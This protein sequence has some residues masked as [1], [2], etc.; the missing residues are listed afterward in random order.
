MPSNILAIGDI[1]GQPGRKALG[2]LLGDLR[3]DYQAELVIANAENAAGGLGVTPEVARE[4]L[5]YGVDVITSG[6]HIWTHKEIIPHLDGDLPLLR[7]L[8][9]PPGVAGRGYLIKDGFLVINLIGRTFLGEFDCPFRTIDDLLSKLNGRG[10]M[11]VVDFHAEA[12]SEKVAMGY[13]LD[14]RVGAVLGTHTHVA[15]ADERILPCGTAYITDLGMAG[16]IDSVIG[17][18]VQAVIRRF[19]TATPS[20]LPVAKGRAML[21]GAM[22]TLDEKTGLALRIERVYREA[23]E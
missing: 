12:T 5:G 23:T 7:P 15:T 9:Y 8:N 18:D 14:G 16:A 3:N 19:L 22:V 11:A 17:D 10:L 21:S 13:Y 6:N 4:L 2:E 1:V 20:R